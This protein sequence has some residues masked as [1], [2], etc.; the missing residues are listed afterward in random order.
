MNCVNDYCTE[1]HLTYYAY[2]SV[3]HFNKMVTNNPKIE[4]VFENS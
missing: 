2:D 1:N 4:L 3:W